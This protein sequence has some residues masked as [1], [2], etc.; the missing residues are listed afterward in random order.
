MAKSTS[1]VTIDRRQVILALVFVVALYVLLPQFSIF[2][3]SR[4]LLG[5]LKLTWTL[6]AIGLV[7]ITYI[8][9]ALTYCLLS[10]RKLRFREV[11]LVQLAATAVNRLLPAGIG[12]LGANYAYLHHRK[13]NGTQAATVVAVNNLLG[14]MGH[15]LIVLLVLLFSSDYS[16]HLAANS[17]H[18]IKMTALITGLILVGI[19]IVALFTGKHLKRTVSTIASQMAVYSH[20][21]WRP[22]GAL[23]SSMG[24]TLCNVLCLYACMMALGVHLPFIVIVLIFTFGLSTGT[25]TPTPGGLGGFEAG[26]VAGF[27]AYHVGSAPALAIALL[28]RLISYWMVLVLGVFA[29]IVAQRKHLFGTSQQSSD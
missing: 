17:E 19:L 12:A 3:D 20:R 15:V 11:L 5:H 25:V 26:L 4:T 13:H 14:I 8:F 6:L 23:L 7:L 2:R 22:G 29:F 1:K 28:F 21:P 24:L 10:L 27:V 16:R 9:A 18:K